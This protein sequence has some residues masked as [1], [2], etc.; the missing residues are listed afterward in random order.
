MEYHSHVIPIPKLCH[1]DIF[2][3]FVVTIALVIDKLAALE[4]VTLLL[5]V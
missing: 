1:I 4:I 2:A 5:R 3:A